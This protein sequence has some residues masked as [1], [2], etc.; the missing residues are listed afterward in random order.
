MVQCVRNIVGGNQHYNRTKNHTKPKSKPQV[1]SWWNPPMLQVGRAIADPNPLFRPSCHAVRHVLCKTNPIASK[2][3]TPQLPV[4]QRL[5]K[6]SRPN[7]PQKNKPNQTQFPRAGKEPKI[8]ERSGNPD[9]SGLERSGSPD[10]SGE[11]KPRPEQGPGARR[12]CTSGYE[13]RKT[14]PI[15]KTQKPPQ[16]SVLQAVTPISRPA[17]REKTNPI[18]PNSSTPTNT[19]NPHSCPNSH[20]KARTRTHDIQH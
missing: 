9:P 4:L 6:T 3:K 2:T 19:P 11:A 13:I 16:P 20:P 10:L 8:L 18:K 15:S 5:T 1:R 7:P 17:A 14:N 12:E